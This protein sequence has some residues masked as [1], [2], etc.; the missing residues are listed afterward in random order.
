MISTFLAS[1][2]LAASAGLNAY[3]PILI[4]ALTDRLTEVVELPQP[5]DIISTNWG[6]I[7]LLVLLPIELVA[8][9]IPRVDHVSDLIHAPI[10]PAAAAFLAMAIAAASDELNLVVAL[11]LGLLVG[12]AVHAYKT[13]S[14]P[15][16]TVSTKGIGNPLVSMSED[17]LVILTAVVSVFVPLGVLFVV[18]LSAYLLYSQYSRLKRG[19]SRFTSLLSGQ[20]ASR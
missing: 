20:S 4:L 3:L 15:G 9:K 11:V 13:V 6:L 14:R 1:F 2:G 12:G 8:D 17:V 7:V 18:P 5:Y 10:R 16:I 19:E